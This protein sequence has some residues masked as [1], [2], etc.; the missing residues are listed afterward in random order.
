MTVGWFVGM[1]TVAEAVELPTVPLRPLL[2]TVLMT[3]PDC[4]LTVILS[5]VPSGMLLAAK[6]TVGVD[7][8][9]GRTKSGVANDPVS[10]AGALTP[11]REVMVSV[12]LLVSVAGS[13]WLIDD[14]TEA[15]ALPGNANA[16][17]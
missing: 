14:T 7:V 8:P 17:E 6:F 4:P 10:V 3:P 9:P 15:G 13:V 12:G 11:P 16:P 5:V 1:V 2:V